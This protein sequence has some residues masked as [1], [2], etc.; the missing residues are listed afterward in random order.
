[1][2]G[3]ELLRLCAIVA[4]EFFCDV[5]LIVAKGLFEQIQDLSFD[6][7]VVGVEFF[8][9]VFHRVFSEVD[10]SALF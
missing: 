1:M 2:H 8:V 5:P 4:F 3:N 6:F 10:H 9:D 7:L